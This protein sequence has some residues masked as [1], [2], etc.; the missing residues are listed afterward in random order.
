MFEA[1]KNF[2]SAVWKRLT[3]SGEVI[4]I[5]EAPKKLPVDPKPNA[6]PEAQT[7][8]QLALKIAVKEIGVVEISGVKDNPRIV[9]YHKYTTLKATDD[10]TPWCS[11]FV[12]FCISKAGGVPTSSAL[13]RSW[14]KWGVAVSTPEPGD[15][16]VFSSSRGVSAGHV[17]FVYKNR[18]AYLEVLGGNQDNQV[19][20]STYTKLRV[21]GY[22]RA[23]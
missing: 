4:K 20:I 6:P 12:N 8:N 22:R 18:G 23:K 19:K 21:L 5:P 11:S 9:E 7:I 16:V 1:I 17:G 15:I 13:A 3:E 2:F 14:L 10:E